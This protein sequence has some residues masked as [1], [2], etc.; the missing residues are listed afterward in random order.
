MFTCE[1]PLFLFCRN[2]NG[3]QFTHWIGKQMD[4]SS[5][6]FDNT[7]TGYSGFDNQRPEKKRAQ[8]AIVHFIHRL[9]IQICAGS[10]TK[11]GTIGGY[12]V[13]N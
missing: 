4:S 10:I 8:Y 5:G 2:V 7:A 6:G 13:L 1:H 11:S 3:Q 9:F 12:R